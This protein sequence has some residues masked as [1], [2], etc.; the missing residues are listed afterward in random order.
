MLTMTTILVAGSL[1]LMAGMLGG[2]V[3]LATGTRRLEPAHVEPDE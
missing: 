2:L 1:L 3:V